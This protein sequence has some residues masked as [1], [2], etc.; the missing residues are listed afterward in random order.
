MCAWHSIVLPGRWWTC[1]GR[2][3]RWNS[4]HCPIHLYCHVVIQ[5]FVN[6][7]VEVA[8]ITVQCGNF[9][10]SHRKLQCCRL[11]SSGM[12][13]CVFGRVVA[14]FSQF[15]HLQVQEINFIPSSL[16]MKT[17][18]VFETSRTTRQRTLPHVLG[19]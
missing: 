2:N 14:H 7:S 3:L 5:C 17:M 4:M 12:W 13:C 6:N 8:F 19:D 16:K 1:T 10:R 9:N 18:R 11:Q 15:L